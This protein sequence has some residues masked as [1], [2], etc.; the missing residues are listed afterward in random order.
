MSD[1]AK[2]TEYFV[3]N[4][5]MLTHIFVLVD[6]VYLTEPLVKSQEFVRS[7]R[8][9]PAGTWLWVCDPVVEIAT[10]EEGVV[11]AYLPGEHPFKDEFARRHSCPRSPSAVA[12]RTMYP[13]FQEVLKKLPEAADRCRRPQRW[14]AAQC[15]DGRTWPAS[16]QGRSMRH[17]Q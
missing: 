6:P 9:L 4:G 3:R 14:R 11:P 5:D 8:E 12:P 1:Q 13:E 16:R 2:M 10:R 7:T 15:S 17:G